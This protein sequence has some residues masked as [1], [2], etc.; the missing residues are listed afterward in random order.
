M[1]LFSASVKRTIV[2]CQLALTSSAY[3]L[4]K[5]SQLFDHDY[6]R[7]ANPDINAGKMDLLVHF[8]KWGDREFRSPS[9]YFSSHYYLSRFHKDEQNSIVPLLHFLLEGGAGGKD[10]NPLFHMEYYLKRYPDVGETRENPL[11]YY[12]K[13]G[14]KKGQFTCPEMEY[15]LEDSLLKTLLERNINP[16]G[17]LLRRQPYSGFDPEYY[18]DRSPAVVESGLSPWEHYVYYGAAEGKSPLPLF[19]P[20][21]YKRQHS[22]ISEYCRD[23]YSHFQAGNT[24]TCLRPSEWFD[25][26]FYRQNSMTSENGGK[27]PLVHY[28]DQG[29][30]AGCYTDGRVAGL[31]EKPLISIIVPVY[32]VQASYLNN[33]IRSVLHQAYPHWEL[34]LADD[35][36]TEKHVRPLLEKW[37][38]VDPRINVVYLEENKG[39]AGATE[40]AVKMA[41]GD[42]LAF[43]D[44]DDELTVDA[45]YQIVK[46]LLE[47]GADLLYSDE[48]L[49]GD[50]GTCF[51]T[52][53]K[54]DYNREL[55]LC[56][57][58]ITHLLV[59]SRELY[60][61]SG[62][63]CSE[64]DGAQDYDLVLK[65]C[66]RAKKVDH[67]NMVL[68]HWRASETSTSINHQQKSYADRAGRKAVEKA[69]IRLKR[70]GEVL[71]TSW[72][73][74]YNPRYVISGLSGVSII[75]TRL[76]MVENIRSHVKD[77]C[78][79]IGYKHF[80][81]I[82]LL[83]ENSEIDEGEN[84]QPAED[85]KV[86]FL[87]FSENEST[88]CRLN[89]AASQATGEFLVFLDGSYTI[90][91]EQWLESLL[92]FARFEDVGFVT[93]LVS[94]A[95]S[96]KI[97]RVPDLQNRSPGYYLQWITGCSV[98]MNGLQCSQQVMMVSGDFCLVRK[99]FFEQF[100][101]VNE[102]LFPALFCLCDL[103]L[104]MHDHGLKNIFCTDSRIIPADTVLRDKV[105]ND[106][107][108]AGL[109]RARFQE[110]W[111]ALL[112]AGDPYYNPGCYREAGLE[113]TEFERWYRGDFR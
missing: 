112:Q 96:W 37:C 87:F 18:L 113:D 16:L 90:A 41:K 94:V 66:H 46:A 82:L 44:N 108:E 54:P 70:E 35:C 17:F 8:V 62:G 26:L 39:I 55:L 42:F 91:G 56:H 1:V 2:R 32:N 11:V 103:S 3:R 29:V 69:L 88:A 84:I 21:Y 81:V 74:F 40:E 98:H 9:I 99:A 78:G 13:Y 49:I 24:A 67:I 104:E 27:N 25:P 33:C 106:R 89:R 20:H 57:N 76:E 107:S 58:Y 111:S 109:E 95:E 50:D 68:Y 101:G 64:L 59:V 31:P 92:G 79:R 71:A 77:L 102:E 10:P 45:L 28:L 30:S 72:K 15:L 63:V 22:E 80:E 47:G 5:R 83:D 23:L 75:I 65:L 85:F 36:S 73:F 14:W 60:E 100:G 7:K 52:F 93:G 12:L 51:S 34:C 53:Y 97:N 6:Y 86:H 43:L 4:I 19:D 38:G 61:S 110:K 105:E 48:D